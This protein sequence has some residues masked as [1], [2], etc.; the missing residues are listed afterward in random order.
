MKG[1]WSR[2]DGNKQNDIGKYENTITKIHTVNKLSELYE[3]IYAL[4]KNDDIYYVY[5][6]N[7]YYKLIDKDKHKTSDGWVL[8]DDDEIFELESVID[9]NRGNNPHRGEYD[10]GSSY[11]ETIKSFF[12][13]S[14]FSDVD[15]NEVINRDDYGFK[16]ELQN[17]N[18]K[19]L[20]LGENNQNPEI[21]FD[22]DKDNA[23]LRGNCNINPYNLFTGENEITEASSLSVINNKMF[24]IVFDI[25]H[26]SFIENDILP[27]LKQVIPSTTIFSYS[28]EDVENYDPTNRVRKYDM[29]CNN[30]QPINGV[31]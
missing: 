30:K 1:G 29:V 8:L 17:D 9:D 22:D 15:E 31:V 11:L 27:Y 5:G 12:K 14:V 16:I 25:S 18:M 26:R 28:F 19:T 13:K 21:E 2:N 10:G 7:K 3:L 23:I 6:E 20:F 4:I 24:H